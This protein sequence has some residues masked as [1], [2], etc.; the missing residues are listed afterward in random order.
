MEHTENQDSFSFE[1]QTLGFAEDGTQVVVKDVPFITL[2]AMGLK[3]IYYTPTLNKFWVAPGKEL[4]KERFESQYA[5]NLAWDY[6]QWEVVKDKR[7]NKFPC[8]PEN[9]ETKRQELLLKADKSKI[10]FYRDVMDKTSPRS[11][12]NPE[13]LRARLALP[14]AD[15]RMIQRLTSFKI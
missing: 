14:S 10:N 7:V 15:E 13:Q 11:L 1:P 12:Q 8:S 9:I 2:G 3:T 5:Q 6:D 4:S